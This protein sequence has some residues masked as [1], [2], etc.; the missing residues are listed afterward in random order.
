MKELLNK[1]MMY[2][3]IQQMSRNGWK[4][5]KIASFL[6]LN[7]RTVRK[8]LLMT[9]DEFL[10][11]QQFIGN[12]AR[13]LDSF[14]GFVK[15][16]L[17]QYSDTS[18]AQ[19]HDWLKEHYDSFPEVSAKTVYNFV[20][21]V[22]QKFNIPKA[23]HN[24]D[25]NIVH[26]LPFGEQA[27]VDFGQYN[28]RSSKGKRIVVY[29]FTIV[30]SRSRYKYVYF[31][32]VPFTAAL[33]VN[34][35][36]KAFEY[37]EGIP[38]E[39]VY[40]Q[41][42]VFLTDENKGDLVLT[43]QFKAY[44]REMPFKLYFCRKA[45]PQSKGKVENVVKYVKQNF[46][47]NRPFVDIP[48]L[49][50]EALA[51]LKR[52]ANG[53]KHAVTREKPYILWLEEKKHLTTIVSYS[54]NNT[55]TTYPVRQDNSFLYKCNIYTLPEGT[56]KGRGT[57]ITIT[58]TGKELV[59]N[60]IYRNRL[61]THALSTDKGR[62]I[63]NTDHRRDKSKTV[64]KLLLDVAISFPDYDKALPYLEQ[65]CNEKRRYAR[66]QLTAIRKTIQK[67]NPEHITKALAYCIK[68]NIYSASD[69]EA[70]INKYQQN[71]GNQKV[72]VPE[73]PINSLNRKLHEIVPQKSD[74]ENYDAIMKN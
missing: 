52:T 25:F 13:E 10:E 24:R 59:I 14:E 29:F 40:D 70:V 34:A 41:D 2:H 32:P 7:R 61:C 56:Y 74:I 33:A 19:M 1:L 4:V 26:E 20:M 23:I 27:Q 22:R 60:D 37:Y 30:L 42:K 46:L 39:I 53:T 36:Q 72:I 5:A 9:E 67:A 68:N 18:A 28:M 11:Y 45:D 63:A 55:E 54:F 65:L 8:Y 3:Q 51:W 64:K 49:N 58:V 15:V 44:C 66:D 62:I 35:H 16:K 6:V 73:Q 38:R 17:E 71:G 57:E 12:R 47:Y 69:F 21:R 31:S 50:T 48:T 43:Q